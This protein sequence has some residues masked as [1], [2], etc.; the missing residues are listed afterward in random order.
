M[1]AISV[2]LATPCS[3]F[4]RDEIH[5]AKKP[6]PDGFDAFDRFARAL[7]SV[8]KSEVDAEQ[9]KVDCRKARRKKKASK[10][11]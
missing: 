6:Q 1:L 9:R 11:K 2:G 5:M 4:F 10:K 7:V 8:P 3:I